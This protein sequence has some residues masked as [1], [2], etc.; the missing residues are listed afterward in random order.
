MAPLTVQAI[1]NV[2]D[3][4]VKR[5]TFTPNNTDL[6]GASTGTVVVTISKA[7]P[8]LTQRCCWYP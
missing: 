6:Y 1:T 8:S 7:T 3:S 2:A 5:V 4:G